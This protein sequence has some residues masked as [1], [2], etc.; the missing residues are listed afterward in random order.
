VAVLRAPSF[1]VVPSDK[2]VKRTIKML[3]TTHIGTEVTKSITVLTSVEYEEDADQLVELRIWQT[4]ESARTFQYKI[5][6]SRKSF[7][8]A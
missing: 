6:K 7:W 4:N 2:L 5:L 8:F 1:S 3:T